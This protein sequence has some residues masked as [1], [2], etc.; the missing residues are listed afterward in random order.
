MSADYC[1]SPTTRVQRY[2]EKTGRDLS[3]LQWYQAFAAWKLGIVLEAS[4]AK[5]T[6]GVSNHPNHEFFGYLVDQLMQRAQRFAVD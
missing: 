3:G 6:S 1:Q 4:Y 5:Y 2:A